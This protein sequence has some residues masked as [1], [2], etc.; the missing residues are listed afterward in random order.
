MEKKAKVKTLL[1]CVKAFFSASLPHSTFSRKILFVV[2]KKKYLKFQK[3]ILLHWEQPLRE[4]HY[5][6]GLDFLTRIGL[7]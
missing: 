1:F 6:S 4:K 7:L 3:K 2:E 5:I